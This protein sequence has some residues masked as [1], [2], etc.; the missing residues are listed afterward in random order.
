MSVLW[1]ESNKSANT[2]TWNSLALASACIC[3]EY[4]VDIVQVTLVTLSLLS[5]SLFKS[6]LSNTLSFFALRQENQCHSFSWEIVLTFLSIFYCLSIKECQNHFVI[7]FKRISRS[8]LHPFLI[9]LVTKNFVVIF[10]IQSF[11][12]HTNILEKIIEA[13]TCHWKFC[14]LSLNK[15]IIKI[16]HPEMFL[17]IM[18]PLDWNL[19]KLWLK[20]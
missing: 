5:S 10:E 4:N 13:L 16:T 18:L 12:L 17:A 19:F 3:N 11:I 20:L 14:V 15:K 8:N 1:M 2:V 6:L 7:G 9:K